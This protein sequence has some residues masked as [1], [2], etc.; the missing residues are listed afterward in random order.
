MGHLGGQIKHMRCRSKWKSINFH[1]ISQFFILRWN[2]AFKGSDQALDQINVPRYLQKKF[3]TCSY[4]VISL[5]KAQLTWTS[6]WCSIPQQ[7]ELMLLPKSGSP[8]WSPW[9]SRSRASSWTFSP[10]SGF[11]RSPPCYLPP[12]L[13]ETRDYFFH[14]FTHL[15]RVFWIVVTPKQVWED[16][17]LCSFEVTSLHLK[18]I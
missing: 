10:T 13:S 14:H 4:P 11:H 3:I 12:L 6:P 9:G 8:P 1:P 16:L 15:H 7:S 2:Q 17:K 5:A 18:Y